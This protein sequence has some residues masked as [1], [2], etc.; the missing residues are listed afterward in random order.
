M[1]RPP[2]I[3]D[4]SVTAARWPRYDDYR[5]DSEG[6][7]LYAVGE[8]TDR[9]QP[10]RFPQLV[11]DLAKVETEQDILSFSR[12]WGP[13]LYTGGTALGIPTAWITGLADNVRLVLGMYE[14]RN[15]EDTVKALLQSHTAGERKSLGPY[16]EIVG[17]QGEQPWPYFW[18][19]QLRAEG[20]A[21][22]RTQSRIAFILN[23]QLGEGL[24]YF[25]EYD[26]PHRLVPRCS[27]L[28]LAVLWHLARIVTGG[29]QV[30]N[31]LKCGVAFVVTDQRQIYCPPQLNPR[32]SPGSACGAADRQQ[33]MRSK[34]KQ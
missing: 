18:A 33:R 30:R 11:T 2:A 20:A 6:G 17:P 25:I 4:D 5:L 28:S 29:R 13:L 14:H 12:S 1:T 7:S 22:S 34:K 23:R 3:D 16:V 19:L 24:G 26:P 15:D 27:A 9:Y 8:V 32:G 21:E 10:F 31:C